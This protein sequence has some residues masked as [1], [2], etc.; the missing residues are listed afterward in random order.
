M[1][2]FTPGGIRC[3]E[4]YAQGK[5]LDHSWWSG[6]MARGITPSDTDMFIESAGCFLWCEISRDCETIEDICRASKGQGI[7]LR[8]LSRIQGMHAVA[9]LCHG[10]FSLSRPINTATD[11]RTATVYFNSG[12]SVVTLDGEQWRSLACLWSENPVSAVRWLESVGAGG[13]KP[14]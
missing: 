1:R 3:P 9:V 4:A 7:A 14:K 12:A 10:L 13:V 8:R 5:M 6:Q 11:I 2:Q